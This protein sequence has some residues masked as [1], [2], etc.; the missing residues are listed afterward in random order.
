ML[1][2][3]RWVFSD[4]R[5]ALR[6]LINLSPVYDSW[7][8]GH[9]SCVYLRIY[10]HPCDRPANTFSDASQSDI[11]WNVYFYAGQ[12]IDVRA[13]PRSHDKLTS[14]DAASLHYKLAFKSQ[15]RYMIPLLFWSAEWISKN[16]LDMAEQAMM[17]ALSTYQPWVLKDVN[18]EKNSAQIVEHQRQAQFLTVTAQATAQKISWP[19]LNPFGCNISSPVFVTGVNKFINC[20]RMP[21]GDSN[22]RTF[23][24]YRV[25]RTAQKVGAELWN[26]SITLFDPDTITS[27]M[28]TFSFKPE[29]K[30][31]RLQQPGVRY[32]VFEVMDDKK[33]HSNAWVGMPSVGPFQNFDRP[34]SLAVRV[35]WLMK[36]RVNGIAAH[37]K[38]STW[39]STLSDSGW[40]RGILRAWYAFTELS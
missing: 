20:I 10:T 15:H 2:E 21:A 37:C 5:F 4:G 39:I 14:S 9:G 18:P 29:N 19:R 31:M 40:S 23:T 35:E 38:G 13:R 36:A 22:L 26:L 24:T 28:M 3:V 7:P 11:N 12:G 32:L 1:P 34:S 30:A 6:D 16:L 25:R 27:S 8:A 17:L 33:P